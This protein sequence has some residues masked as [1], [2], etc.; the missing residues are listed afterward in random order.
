MCIFKGILCDKVLS[1]E[2]FASMTELQSKQILDQHRIISQK[3][4]E[5]FNLKRNFEL[6]AEQHYREVEIL[7]ERIESLEWRKVKSIY[8]GAEC[9]SDEFS[10]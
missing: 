8:P 10:R 7:K 5:I 4:A 2:Q 9:E 6:Q 1:H 3:D